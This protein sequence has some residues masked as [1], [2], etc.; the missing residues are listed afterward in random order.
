[1]T[2]QVCQCSWFLWH[3]H[4]G[5]DTLPPALPSKSD[6]DVEAVATVMGRYPAHT[7]VSADVLGQAEPV[8]DLARDVR[9]CR[10]CPGGGA[11]APSTS[12]RPSAARSCRLQPRRGRTSAARPGPWP[13]PRR[14]PRWSRRPAQRTVS[15]GNGPCYGVA[16]TGDAMDG[17]RTRLVRCDGGLVCG[18]GADA[19]RRGLGL[20]PDGQ[21]IR[22]GGPGEA[23]DRH[24]RVDGLVL[25]S[26]DLERLVPDAN[27]A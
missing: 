11:G 9:I 3:H 17:R 10:S 21:V 25:P 12:R 8:H 22:P 20:L 5:H 16:S 15:R 23:E 14:S 26:P 1:V 24:V 4:P 19:R 2:S 13:G 6:Y 27:L 18:T 7:S